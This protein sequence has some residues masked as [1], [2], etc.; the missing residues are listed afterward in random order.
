[1]QSSDTFRRS[2]RAGHDPRYTLS[3]D[4]PRIHDRTF[5][6]N[7]HF[8]DSTRGAEF[9]QLRNN[10][11]DQDPRASSPS[12]LILG[13]HENGRSRIG[14]TQIDSNSANATQIV[15]AVMTDLAIPQAITNLDT[16]HRYDIVFRNS[17]KR[18]TRETPRSSATLTTTFWPNTTPC[19]RDANSYRP[20][21]RSRF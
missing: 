9:L 10:S 14:S 21:P 11:P 2:L 1:M 20:R 18:C 17:S 4:R 16:T 5:N 8:D 15:E 12:R 13:W 7:K 6:P 19:T 3:P